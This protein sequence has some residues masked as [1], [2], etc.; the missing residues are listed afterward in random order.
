MKI[1]LQ[2]HPIPWLHSVRFDT[3]RGVGRVRWFRSGLELHGWAMKIAG[4]WFA[5]YPEG[6]VFIFQ[7]GTRC[8]PMDSTTTCS[9]TRTG[10]MRTFRIMRGPEVELEVRYRA[11]DRDWDVAYDEGDL[12]DDDL[13]FFAAF[14][15]GRRAGNDR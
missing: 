13:L 5:I 1:D 2:W 3:V 11:R 4:I 8:W 15:W 14:K 7:A 9:N 10:R 6:D 12:M